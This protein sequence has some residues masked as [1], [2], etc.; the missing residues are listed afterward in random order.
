MEAEIDRDGRAFV[1]RVTFESG[2]VWS[3]SD[4]GASRSLESFLPKAHAWLKEV[5]CTSE[6]RMRAADAE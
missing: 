5:G 4:G 3:F 2:A 1:A 6:P